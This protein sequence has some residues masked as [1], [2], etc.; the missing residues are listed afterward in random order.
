MAA[1]CD[2]LV[3][4]ERVRALQLLLAPDAEPLADGAPLPPLWHWVAL[5]NWTDPGSTGPDGHPVRPSR[6]AGTPVRRMFAGGEVVYGSGVLQ[7]GDR[8]AHTTAL[9]WVAEKTGRSGTFTLATFE[10]QI[11]SSSGEVLLT[12]RQDVVYVDPTAN[13]LD[14]PDGA[15]PIVGRPLQTRA[16]G[17]VELH[18]DPTILLRFSA[19]T[20]NPHRIHYDLAYAREV[21]RLP[22]L[23]VHGPLIN[24]VLAG[25]AAPDGSV[26]RIRH[27]NLS[28]LFA[29]QHAVLAATEEGTS[30][31]EVT[32][33]A[34]SPDGRTISRVVVE[35]DD[36]EE[37]NPQP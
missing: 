29:G 5:P 12:E 4:G 19:L 18:T 2:V 16:D 37:G 20:G 36:A 17:A 1:S 21:E 7:V 9:T 35:S 33:E 27:R 23:L 30:A 8:V 28:P 26:R 34:T 13:D 32:A 24:L 15:L 22:G 6:L 3:D 14:A 11:T 31:R 25:L 10:S